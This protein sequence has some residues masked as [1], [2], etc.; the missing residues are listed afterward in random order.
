MISKTGLSQ[1]KF[2]ALLDEDLER[3]KNVLNG[4]I[5]PPADLVR[6]V[7]ERCQVDAMWFLSGRELDI[8]ELAPIEKI[9]IANLRR[10]SAAERT[11]M[12]RCIAQLAAEREK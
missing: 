1:P 12:T 11:V 7:I 9:L 6:K 3:L 2:A 5:R 4:K 10:L 8:G